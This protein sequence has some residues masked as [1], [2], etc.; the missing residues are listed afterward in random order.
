[1]LTHKKKVKYGRL[2]DPISISKEKG[3]KYI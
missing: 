1:M 3:N 2:K